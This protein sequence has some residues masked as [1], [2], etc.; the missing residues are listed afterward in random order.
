YGEKAIILDDENEK[1]THLS[2]LEVN[3]EN[4]AYMIYTSGSTSRPKGVVNTH[5]GIRNRILWMQEAFQLSSDDCI[6][7]KTPYSFDVS[8]WEFLWPFM[9]GAK[10]V[11]AKPEGHK[12][13]DYLI[14]LI[15]KES[16]TTIH[17]VP[18][19]L[20]VFLAN[21]RSSECISLRRVIC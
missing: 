3:S 2:E 18:S 8:V 9:A 17:F 20:K 4:A 16:I 14:D 19:M 5:G 13:P 6:L 10:L 12:D 15:K 11:V 1:K 7:Q 21:P